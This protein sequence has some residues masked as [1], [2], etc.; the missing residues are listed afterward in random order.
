MPKAMEKSLKSQARKKG[1]NKKKTNAYVYGTMRKAG[2]K[3]R[4][5]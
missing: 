4:K 1:L 5:K 3:P 2:W